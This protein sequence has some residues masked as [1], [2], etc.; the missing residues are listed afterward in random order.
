MVTA[1]II[2]YI[3]LTVF[4][5]N[6]LLII[7]VI[8]LN[9]R[10][11]ETTPF[12]IVVAAILPIIGFIIFLLLGHT[13]FID[14]RF[15]LKAEDDIKVKHLANEQIIMLE[16]VDEEDLN[17]PVMLGFVDMAHMLLLNDD[18]VITTNN[19]VKNYSDGNE[20]FDDFLDDIANA[21]EHIHI[22][23]YIIR[24]DD[25]G[26]KFVSA[27]AAKAREGVEVRLLKDGVGCKALPSNFFKELTDAGGE[28]VGFFERSLGVYIRFN[29]RNH[30][31]IAIFDGLVAYVG[32]YN[33]GDEYL[34]LGP[35][36]NWRDAAMRIEGYGALTAQIRFMLDW[37]Y[38][39]G[40]LRDF[41]PKYFPK[42]EEYEGTSV[43]IV[44][45]GPD[46]FDE[47][48]KH[49][50]IKMINSAKESVYLTTPYFIPDK[51]VA[52]ALRIAAMSGV[53]VRMIIPC[54]PDHMLIYWATYA[55]VGWLLENGVR[56]FKYDD[57]FIHAKSMVVD[58]AVGSVG[59]ANFD[60]RSFK[61]NF[62]TQAF[63][64]NKEVG[65]DLKRRFIEDIDERCS[66]LTLDDYK[67]R[68]NIIK[69]KETFALLFGDLL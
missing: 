36:G 9:R 57:G 63:V 50:Y 22:E 40:K 14:K 30:R 54:K 5:I 16:Q 66:E 42:Q 49:A 41:D 29:H 35:L 1:I 10:Y 20:K 13:H 64:Y 65:E 34:G 3:E 44:S 17:D 31:K 58:G 68:S 23:Y 47:K 4:F 19:N 11:P 60:I 32:G 25:L 69:M 12:W 39:T 7:L 21:K 38:E 48:I 2:E 53:D 61:L 24:N 67:D 37:S 51:A 62:E 6:I 56:A 18:A 52:D 59:S 43:Q 46:S 28:V 33:I 45:S 26:K 27:L 55:H 8:Y 15:R